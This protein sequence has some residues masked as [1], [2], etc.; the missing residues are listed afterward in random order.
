MTEKEWNSLKVGQTV[1]YG[2][3]K[4][5]RVIR[6]NNLHRSITLDI[7]VKSKLDHP[8]TIYPKNTRHLF[9]LTKI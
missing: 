3:K 6:F 4:T 5:P 2:P 8:E 1:Y 7:L 9:F